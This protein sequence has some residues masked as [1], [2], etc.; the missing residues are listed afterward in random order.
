MAYVFVSLSLIF[1]T[2]KGYLGKKTS[3]CVSNSGDAVL[4]SLVR[5]LLCIIIGLVPVAFD[6]AWSF[7][8]LDGGMAAICLLVG[9]ANAVYISSWILAVQDNAMVTVDVMLT[10]GSIIPAVLCHILDWERLRMPKVLGFLIVILATVILAGGSKKVRK[11]KSFW[12]ILLPILS[13]VGEGMVSFSQQLYKQYYSSSDALAGKMYP[14]SIYHFYT[15]VIASLFLLVF[16]VVYRQVSVSKMKAAGT[17]EHVSC[18]APLKKTFWFIA[19]MA[20]CMFVAAYFQTEATSNHG[21][22]SQVMYPLIKAG[23]LVLNAFMAQFAFGEKITRRRVL[24]VLIA[25]VG[26]IVMNV[27]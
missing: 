1:L 12:V 5:M 8:A 25:L 20:V 11:K 13:A 26:I 10:I 7:L 4:F 27:F 24:G 15:Y 23:S 3:T 6:N 9:A 17:Y 2:V 14:M 21:M 18:L 16:F 22:S 19:M